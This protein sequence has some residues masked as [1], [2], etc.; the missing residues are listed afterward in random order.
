MYRQAS[1]QR[2]MQTADL[3]SKGCDMER[4]RGSAPE[5]RHFCVNH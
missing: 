4:R 1:P 3:D 2:A 5:R